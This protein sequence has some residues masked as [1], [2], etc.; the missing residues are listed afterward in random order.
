[1]VSQPSE[2]PD[3]KLREATEGYGKVPTAKSIETRFEVPARE[4]DLVPNSRSVKIR[5]GP[6]LVPNKTQKNLA[7]EE[8]VLYN[9]PDRD[10]E[11]LV[12]SYR[13]YYSLISVDHVMMIVP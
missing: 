12:S 10:V 6:Y 5:Y 9:Y 4:K 3:I 8:G 1:M 11:K 7:G 2:C 13:A